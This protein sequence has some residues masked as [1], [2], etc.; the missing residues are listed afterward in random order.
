MKERERS[1]ESERGIK[2]NRDSRRKR[3]RDKEVSGNGNDC[4]MISFTC[5]Q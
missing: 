4:G 1:R 3:G 2:E 5:N